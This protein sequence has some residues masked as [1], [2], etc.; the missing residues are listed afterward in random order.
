VEPFRYYQYGERVVAFP[1]WILD[2]AGEG[3]RTVMGMG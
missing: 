2:P 1:I 3:D